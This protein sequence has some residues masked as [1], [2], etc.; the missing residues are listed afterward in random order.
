[1]K[2]PRWIVP[3]MLKFYA[4]VVAKMKTHLMLNKFFFEILPFTR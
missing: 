2:T 1:M 4:E 3:E